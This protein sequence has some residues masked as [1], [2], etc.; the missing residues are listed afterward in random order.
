M[1]TLNPFPPAWVTIVL[2]VKP[3]VSFVQ[4]I[5]TSTEVETFRYINRPEELR[6]GA[7]SIHLSV[8]V[9]VKQT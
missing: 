9:F 3:L 6:G 7:F 8:S 2:D 5:L 1:K 4:N